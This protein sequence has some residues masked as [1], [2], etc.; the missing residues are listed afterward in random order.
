MIRNGLK[1][2]VT[3]GGVFAQDR[4]EVTRGRGVH[5]I[6]QGSQRQSG[7]ITLYIDAYDHIGE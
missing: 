1:Q 4:R 3:Q 2:V 6:F 7:Q 5:P